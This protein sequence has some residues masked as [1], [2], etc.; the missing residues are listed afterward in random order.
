MAPN[1]KNYRKQ[2]ADTKQ[3]KIE[4]DN[5]FKSNF[6]KNAMSGDIF[7]APVK[8]EPVYFDTLPEFNPE[9]SQCF[10]D[11]KV[12]TPD[13][14]DENYKNKPIHRIIFELFTNQVPKTAENFRCLCTGE[15]SARLHYKNNFFHRIAKGFVI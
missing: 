12:G 7:E 2:F 3:L 13:I 5:H 6:L 9:N 4:A 11:I 8:K 14:H 15:K 10:F 1:D